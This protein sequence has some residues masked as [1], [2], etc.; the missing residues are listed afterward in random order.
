MSIVLNCQRLWKIVQNVGRRIYSLG[1]QRKPIPKFP[2]TEEFARRGQCA[3]AVHVQEIT[4]I[5]T[6]RPGRRITQTKA[7][8]AA[9]RMRLKKFLLSGSEGGR[10]GDGD[11]KNSKKATETDGPAEAAGRAL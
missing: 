6:A 2:E 3:H 5:R 10:G 1:A 7:T 11:A 8:A 9:Q 4:K